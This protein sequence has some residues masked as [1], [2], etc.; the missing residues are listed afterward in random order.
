M[1]MRSVKVGQKKQIV[2]PKETRDLPGIQ[3]GSTLLPADVNK[4][5][6]IRR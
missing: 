4:G 1:Y 5:I 6:V 2:M 3:P